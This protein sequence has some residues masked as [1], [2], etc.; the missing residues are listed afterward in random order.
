MENGEC[1]TQILCTTMDNFDVN[2]LYDLLNIFCPY[3][4]CE[5]KD[6]TEVKSLRRH[7]FVLRK[8]PK[9]DK[10]IVNVEILRIPGPK[11]WYSKYILSYV[12]KK[13][14]CGGIKGKVYC[15]FDVIQKITAEQWKNIRPFLC[16]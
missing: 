15:N 1:N 11:I 16:Y 6:C 3:L 10:I 5:I 9:V 7:S 14:L 4:D 13:D 8:M 2:F 12:L